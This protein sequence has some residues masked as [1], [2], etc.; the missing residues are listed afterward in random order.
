MSQLPQSCCAGPTLRAGCCSH[1]SALNR[2]YSFCR[3]AF[4]PGF[5]TSWQAGGQVAAVM[6]L[7]ELQ[8]SVMGLELQTGI[9]WLYSSQN[10]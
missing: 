4:M 5:E 10:L 2:S 3:H 9:A 6:P 8:Q 1:V 7:G